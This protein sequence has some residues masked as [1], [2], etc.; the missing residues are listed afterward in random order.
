MEDNN[1]GAKEVLPHPGTN[2]VPSQGL[3]DGAPGSSLSLVFT[4]ATRRTLPTV[5]MEPQKR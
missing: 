2:D 5:E 1:R 4:G 3:F